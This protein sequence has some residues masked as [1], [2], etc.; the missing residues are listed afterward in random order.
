M[1]V[2]QATSPELIVSSR[3]TLWRYMSVSRFR[4][5]LTSKKMRFTRADQFSDNWDGMLPPSV[6][7]ALAKAKSSSSSQITMPALIPYSDSPISEE[8]MIRMLT[9]DQ[10]TEAYVSCWSANRGESAA[11]W[12]LYSPR[13]RGVAIK[14]S[15]GRLMESLSASP[16][17][18]I[19]GKVQY[20]RTRSKHTDGIIHLADTALGPLFIKR[21]EFKHET[22]V[23]VMFWN[24]ADESGEPLPCDLDIPKARKV[25][26]SFR[27]LIS[28]VVL[29]PGC[30]ASI[31]AD[32]QSLVAKFGISSGRVLISK[33]YDKP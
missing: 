1:P 25:P 15:V 11:M 13:G 33:L 18:M 8:F 26:V 5:L 6:L 9:Y 14:S 12:D 24:L 28:K 10:K 4:Q 21:V 20:A 30:S 27:T 7:S 17:R 19:I 31:Q 3:T 29:S 22:E 23:R 16:L 32:I 2:F